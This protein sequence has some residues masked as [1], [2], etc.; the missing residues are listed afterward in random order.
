[1]AKQPAPAEATDTL[2]LNVVEAEEAKEHM[3]ATGERVAGATDP[4]SHPATYAA[5]TATASAEGGAGLGYGP[6][7]DPAGTTAA[8]LPVEGL[9]GGAGGEKSGLA[10]AAEG[11]KEALGLK[12]EPSLKAYALP[13]AATATEI[14][15]RLLGIADG[16]VPRTSL[17]GI[18]ESPSMV[19]C[20]SMSACFGSYST[21]LGALF[22]GELQFE[23]NAT[24]TLFLTA[25][26]DAQLWIG[27]QVV[28]PWG[29]SKGVARQY[30][31]LK[32]TAGW[33]PFL[34]GYYAKSSPSGL[35]VRLERSSPGVGSPAQFTISR[36]TINSQ[37]FRPAP[38]KIAS[39]YPQ[40]LDGTLYDSGVHLRVWQPG[41]EV[42][43]MPSF[44]ALPPSALRLDTTL[45]N[46]DCKN[47]DARCF[48]NAGDS[49]DKFASNI[50][51]LFEGYI[52]IPVTGFY[53]FLSEQDKDD[54]DADMT[55]DAETDEPMYV[56]KTGCDTF[57][58]FCEDKGRKKY[59]WYRNLERGWHT[60]RFEFYQGSDN[61]YVT[62][63]W[64]STEYGGN[65][66]T[67]IPSSS[68]K[69]PNS[70][71]LVP[72]AAQPISPTRIPS[73]AQP[74]SST[75][76]PSAA[77]PISPT[78][79]PSAAQPI[80]STLIPSAAQPSSSTLVPSAAQPI[81]PTRIPSAAQPISSTLIPSAAHPKTTLA[82][83]PV[84]T[85]L[86]LTA[87]EP[88][89]TAAA[90]PATGFGGAA[91][92]A[93]STTQ[94][95][96]APT[97]TPALT[98]PAPAITPALTIPAPAITPALTIPAP[99]ITPAL[100]IP[101]P[102]ITPAI[103]IP[104]PAITPSLTI[105]T[106]ALTPTQPLAAPA[107]A[108]ALTTPATAEF[109]LDSQG[110]GGS[111]SSSTC[112]LAGSITLVLTHATD[113]AGP[114]AICFPALG[115][116]VTAGTCELKVFAL[117]SFGL[118]YGS[119]PCPA[120]PLSGGVLSTPADLPAAIAR[121]LKTPSFG[122]RT[123]TNVALA[124]AGGIAATVPGPQA[125]FYSV[126]EGS[127]GSA[128]ID[129][130]PPCTGSAAACTPTLSDGNPACP[131]GRYLA[132]NDRACALCFA[133]S[134]CAGGDAG[135]AL[136]PAG[137]YAERAGL[138]TCRLCGTDQY[139]ANTGA[140]SCSPCPDYSFAH[141]TGSTGCIACY[142]GEPKVVAGKIQGKLGFW[143]GEMPQE[144]APE[145]TG[146]RFFRLAGDALGTCTD[147][148]H[149]FNDPSSGCDSMDRR[150]LALQTDPTCLVRIYVLGD[151]KCSHARS[152]SVV[153]AAYSSLNTIESRPD[154]IRSGVRVRL[155][156]LAGGGGGWEFSLMQAANP[157]VSCSDGVAR[158][159]ESS[160]CP[161]G[162]EATTN[163]QSPTSP[164]VI[165]EQGCIPCQPGDSCPA[166]SQDPV[167]CEP[168]TYNPM[169]G[170]DH[171]TEC[172]SGTISAPGAGAEGCTICNAGTEPHE[173]RSRCILCGE[174]R[175]SATNG[176]ACE[177]CPAGSYRPADAADGVGCMLCSPGSWSAVGAGSCTPCDPGTATDEEGTS[178][179][180][181]TLSCPACNP[182]DYAE[183]YGSQT[184]NIC[185]PGTYSS[186]P[187]AS[188]CSASPA[189]AITV[190]PIGKGA[191]SF[192]QC[193]KGTWRPVD[194]TDNKC[195]S[196]P[197]GYETKVDGTGATTCTPC[198]A[199]FF[200]LQPNTAR[201]SPCVPGT[202][203][204]TSGSRQ[205]KL[206]PSGTV[207]GNGGTGLDAQNATA[208]NPCPR[209]TFRPS[210]YAANVCTLCPKGR[211]TGKESGAVACTACAPGYAHVDAS[212]VNCTA[213]GA[214]SFAASQGTAGTCTACPPGYAVSDSANS[215]CDVCPPGH[216]QDEAG[217]LQCKPCP[218]GTYN[219]MTGST[220]LSACL[221]APRGNYAAGDGNDGFVPCEP[222]TYQD[223][224]GGAA[225][226]VCPPGSE[227]PAGSVIPKPCRPGFFSDLKQPF[228]KA[229]AKGTY[230]DQAA[231]RA[232]KPCP[233]GAYCAA[234][235]MV[236]PTPCPAGRYSTK[237]SSVAANDC[238]KCPI[239]TF[240]AVNGATSCQKCNAT[241][242]TARQTGQ[243][244]CWSTTKR[245]P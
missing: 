113:A 193:P 48:R 19:E 162:T 103:A 159:V 22:Y 87:T 112:P 88:L 122:I 241:Q 83:H 29:G 2:N 10:K 222:G 138:A 94:Q 129:A 200:A 146:F 28:I 79:I 4:Y 52:Y 128:L 131:V 61:G 80:S 153:D 143:W 166:G 51:A 176:A 187:G 196:C 185:P 127:L 33:V 41:G 86:V 99:A 27:G 12:K 46:I 130:A 136:C 78:R 120:G 199:G 227:C 32:F 54:S 230:Q 243:R 116:T 198:D 201:C 84:S 161:A 168:G 15:T 207:S 158:I 132:S 37:Y 77:Q 233:A 36:Q 125:L 163:P 178:Q 118:T 72:S 152:L 6:G 18:N 204:P 109:S 242:W 235:K 100:T 93:V 171:C 62:L 76:I 147:V 195:R 102:A 95:P 209:R 106:P 58:G 165:K 11:L 244:A 184:C 220:S 17:S 81:S 63:S 202:F 225:C 173:Q 182:G 23:R 56:L 213:C 181:V 188:S 192:Q 121:A 9:G 55:L 40:S 236:A 3:Y 44:A 133:G 114:Y 65:T 82:T 45:P 164:V 70:S 140:T 210:L 59:S 91:K 135:P 39:N 215:A 90:I 229:C 85:A 180:P 115:I 98:I 30:G 42:T 104:A 25:N 64:R 14:Q 174:G 5:G 67:I 228:C 108:P 7:N 179:D 191:V 74:S 13:S 124:G 189:G 50:G 111:A 38:I 216:Y 21:N 219:A 26:E 218:Q 142:Y 117:G 126:D 20:T 155:G 101:A 212:D 221:P 183:G 75:L 157:D 53:Q 231:Q 208:C 167:Q 123:L 71:A 190:A 177:D 170:A 232:C 144:Q 16:S 141:F 156:P 35:A 149:P 49:S 110:S 31:P 97:I 43:S 169:V 154:D 194:A 73:A 172:P 234:T 57:Y 223:Q 197:A 160:G 148:A 151:D 89:P 119:Q 34:V 107:I 214:G 186:A 1:M 239:N 137:Q 47:G 8:G 245:L 68:F 238:F 206:C 237:L 217:K 211:E 105:P 226:K 60:I 69:C 205:C 240:S 66:W 92:Y 203:A 224:E 134:S 139:Q 175:F 145:N 150:V 96:L 24:Y